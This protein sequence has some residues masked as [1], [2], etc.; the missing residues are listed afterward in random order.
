LRAPGSHG[1]TSTPAEC[2]RALEVQ[3]TWVRCG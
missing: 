3:V 2:L 1:A